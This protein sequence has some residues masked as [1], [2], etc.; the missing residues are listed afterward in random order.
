MN[1]PKWKW[2]IV[3]QDH[4]VR[5]TN[6]LGVMQAYADAGSGVANIVDTETGKIVGDM[7]LDVQ[8]VADPNAP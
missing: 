8:E 3:F 1:A 5:G 2:L 7:N 4:S 6:E